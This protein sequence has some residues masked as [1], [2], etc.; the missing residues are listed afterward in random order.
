M[1]VDTQQVDIKAEDAD[2][3]KDKKDK[4]RSAWIA[5]AGRI[6]AQLVGAIATVSLGVLMLHR[7]TDSDRQPPANERVP[8]T[9]S[10]PAAWHRGPASPPVIVVL[11]VPD[12]AS[13]PSGESE[14]AADVAARQAE[15]ARA[16][17][18]AVS[19]A[20]PVSP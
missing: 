10:E 15:M 4:V 18:R 16:I 8:S 9:F 12:S 5:F 3:K 13:H 1:S 17:A 19:A 14:P 2:K 11:I 7:Y 20:V 6:I